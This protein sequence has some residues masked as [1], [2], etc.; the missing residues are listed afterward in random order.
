MRIRLFI[1]TILLIIATASCKTTREAYLPL[2]NPW[3]SYEKAIDASQNCE[4]L[5]TVYIAFCK[6]LI[7]LD[8]Q[9]PESEWKS[10]VQTTN[11]LERKM[12]HKARKFCGY[13]YFDNILENAPAMGEGE[14]N[15]IPADDFDFEEWEDNFDYDEF[16][17]T[18]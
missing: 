7:A 16:D 4:Q 18:R 11:Y 2:N 6:R 5:H 13:T 17:A 3:S 12:N 9:I 8:G 10:Y 1:C 15:D 14:E